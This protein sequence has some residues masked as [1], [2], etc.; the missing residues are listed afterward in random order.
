MVQMM[1][2]MITPA[3]LPL[4]QNTFQVHYTNFYEEQDLQEE[5]GPLT[6]TQ[7]DGDTQEDDEQEE[8]HL[9]VAHQEED[10]LEAQDQE[11]I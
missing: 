2:Q 6:T 4:H 5:E 11:Q 8:A 10:P 1:V 7:T 9:K 3:S